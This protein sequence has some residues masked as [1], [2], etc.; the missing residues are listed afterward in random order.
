MTFKT[1]RMTLKTLRAAKTTP[2]LQKYGTEG[3]EIF[4]NIQR[5]TINSVYFTLFPAVL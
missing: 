2:S 4:D 3:V 1:L 5:N